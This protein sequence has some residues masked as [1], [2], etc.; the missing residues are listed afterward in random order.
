MNQLGISKKEE[1]EEEEE[2]AILLDVLRKRSCEAPLT[3][4]RYHRLSQVPMQKL[5]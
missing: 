1:E 2:V 5:L 4:Y 3:I